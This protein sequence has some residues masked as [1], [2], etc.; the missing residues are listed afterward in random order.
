MTKDAHLTD[1]QRENLIS[2]F[3]QLGERTR[4]REERQRYYDAMTHHI[5][6]RTPEQVAKMERARGLR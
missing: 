1:D 4:D 6:N 2:M 5:K 3:R